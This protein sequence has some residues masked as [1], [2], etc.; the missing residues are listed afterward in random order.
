[1]LSQPLEDFAFDWQ[2]VLES[3]EAEREA[4]EEARRNAEHGHSSG[5]M[6]FDTWQQA[7]SD[8]MKESSRKERAERLRS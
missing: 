3:L 8:D 4:T 2:C 7:A 6:S 5:G 1:M